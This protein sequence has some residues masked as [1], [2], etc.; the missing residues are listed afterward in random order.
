MGRLTGTVKLQRFSQDRKILDTRIQPMRSFTKGLIENMYLHHAHLLTGTAYSGGS[1]VDRAARRTFLFTPGTGARSWSNQSSITAPGGLTPVYHTL[2]PTLNSMPA[3]VILSGCDIGIQVGTDNTAVTPTNQRMSR[4]IG[5]GIRQ[6]DAGDA[7]FESCEI[8][9]DSQTTMDS[10]GDWCAQPFIPRRDFRCSSAE[11]KLYKAG[12]PGALTVELVGVNYSMATFFTVP[13]PTVLA[14]GTIAEAAINGASPGAFA[15]VNFGTAVDLYAG[16]MYY[17]QARAPGSS[18]GNSV[19]WRFDT[20]GALYDHAPYPRTIVGTMTHSLT[21]VNSGVAWSHT[22]DKTYMFKLIGRSIG[23]FL[24]GSCDLSNM[25]IADPN[26]SF[27]L[28][29]M[30]RNSSGAAISVAEV[31]ITSLMF[32]PSVVGVEVNNIHPQLIARDVVAPPVAVANGELLLVT[33]TPA[34]M[35]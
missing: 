19:N 29:R 21:S 20:A 16:H 27:D 13:H 11:L 26:A 28:T 8:N 14:T 5:H 30:F 23:E 24:Y 17:L 25:V 18:V 33:Y 35:V 9:D 32:E 2:T 1:D 7:T 12:A 22:D 15:T 3:Y 6:A 34:I 10:V 4:R 31:G